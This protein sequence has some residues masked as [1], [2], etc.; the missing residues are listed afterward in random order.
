MVTRAPRCGGPDGQPAPAGADL[1]HVLPGA[2]PRPGPGCRRSCGAGRR[3]GRRCRRR[4]R[5]TSR[6][7]SRRGTARTARWTGRSGGGC[8]PASPRRC[9]ASSRG[10]AGLDVAP[11][12]PLQRRGD[13]RGQL[14]RERGE[15]VGQLACDGPVAD[16]V[17]LAEADL[18]VGAEPVEERRRA[19][20]SASPGSP[21]RRRRCRCP[22]G[23]TTRTGSVRTAR[24]N[25]AS[26]MR[27]RTGDCGGVARP[28]HTPS[29]GRGAD[30]TTAGRS[31]R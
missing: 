17:G 13:Q 8:S 24:R 9:C 6:S 20:R 22:P 23:N 14:G 25:S 1:Q 21:G 16:H 4:T 18:R 2:H 11:E 29:L 26:A 30:D 15:Q 27:A 7:S 10:L 3:R 28:G 12:Q 19:A 31:E 5:P